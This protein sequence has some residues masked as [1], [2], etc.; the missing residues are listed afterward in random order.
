METH[1]TRDWEERFDERFIPNDGN[2]PTYIE[3]GN[4]LKDFIHQ[5]LQKAREEERRRA[6]KIIEGYMEDDEYWQPIVA[7][8]LGKP[9]TRKKDQSNLDQEANVPKEKRN[10]IKSQPTLDHPT[11]SK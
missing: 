9:T 8:V 2:I 5:E 6:A 1:N 10:F 7:E 3:N 4:D 11:I